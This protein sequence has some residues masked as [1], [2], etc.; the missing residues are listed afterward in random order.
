MSAAAPL[1]RVG[2]AA[3]G[4][5]LQGLDARAQLAAGQPQPVLGDAQALVTQYAREKLGPLGRGELGH[6]RQFL[7]AREVRVEE[8]V[9]AHAEQADQ[10]LGDGPQAVGDRLRVAVLIELGRAEPAH[11][12]VVM[13]T[14][15]EVE[16]DAHGGARRGATA[17]NRFPGPSCG[18]RAVNREG[19]RLQQGRLPR[20]VGADDAG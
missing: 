13:G 10:A 17:P 1:F 16:L 11:D 3:S 6:D 5:R 8:L 2:W 15:C 14:Q 18:R 9:P 4:R 7:L 19:D 20:P 12:A